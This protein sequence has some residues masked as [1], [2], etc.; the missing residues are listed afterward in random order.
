MSRWKQ[1]RAE[2]EA[3]RHETR[4]EIESSLRRELRRAADHDACARSAP[5]WLTHRGTDR[6]WEIYLSTNSDASDGA[7]GAIRLLDLDWLDDAQLSL[8]ARG[9]KAVAEFSFELKGVVRDAKRVW[10][11]RVDLTEEPEGSGLCGHAILHCHVGG[12]PNAVDNQ[13]RAPLPA[14]RPFEVLQWLLAT[15]AKRLE[16]PT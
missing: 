11:T 5:S 8:R 9:D 4:R 2:V 15:V 16:P 7:G 10:Y 12:D 13:F 1:L 3:T 14:L 6:N